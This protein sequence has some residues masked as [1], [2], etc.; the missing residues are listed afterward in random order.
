MEIHIKKDTFERLYRSD[1]EEYTNYLKTEHKLSDGEINKAVRNK[2][3]NDV[4][5]KCE[6]IGMSESEIKAEINKAL[7]KY[8]K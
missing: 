6:D 2:I 1:I 5:W 7:K 8:I 3:S 4:R